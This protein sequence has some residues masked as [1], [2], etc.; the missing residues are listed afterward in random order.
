MT[1]QSRQDT[2]Q[3]QDQNGQYYAALLE[4]EGHRQDA[5]AYDAISEGHHV[6]HLGDHF[7]DFIGLTV[8]RCNFPLF[9][10]MRQAPLN[11]TSH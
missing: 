4:A 5:H 2:A 8:P 7:E 10:S 6:R 11:F 9:N 1:G 3:E